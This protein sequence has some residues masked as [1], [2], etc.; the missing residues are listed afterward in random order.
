M[1]FKFYS[2]FLQPKKRAYG[3]DISGE[4]TEGSGEIANRENQKNVEDTAQPQDHH[5]T[6]PNPA[7]L[8][9]DVD[10]DKQF[11]ELAQY[12]SVKPHWPPRTR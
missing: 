11:P 4:V 9:R 1:S 5:Q 2:K 3:Y 12:K 10:A 8:M 6:P 7:N